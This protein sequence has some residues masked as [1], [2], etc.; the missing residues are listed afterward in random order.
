MTEPVVVKPCG[1]S[2]EV[3]EEPSSECLIPKVGDVRAANHVVIYHAFVHLGVGVGRSSNSLAV[4]FPVVVPRINVG[5]N[6]H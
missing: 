5:A 6:C 4:E 3:A 1:Y 2:A